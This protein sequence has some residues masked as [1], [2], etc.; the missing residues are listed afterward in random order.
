MVNSKSANIK[1]GEKHKLILKHSDFNTLKHA[2]YVS[3]SLLFNKKK[4]LKVCNVHYL[5][6]GPKIVV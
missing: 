2:A 1:S 6:H 4:T 5:S 3:H